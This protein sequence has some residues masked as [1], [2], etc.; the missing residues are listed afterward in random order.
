VQLGGQMKSGQTLCGR[1]LQWF[2]VLRNAER[3]ESVFAGLRD[4]GNFPRFGTPALQR[5]FSYVCTAVGA[6][7][8]RNQANDFYATVRAIESACDGQGPAGLR[9]PNKTPFW[10]A[11]RNEKRRTLKALW[12]RT[13]PIVIAD[14][15]YP[16]LYRDALNV[17]QVLVRQVAVDKLQW[18]AT[19]ADDAETNVNHVWTGPFDSFAFFENYND[20]RDTL[21]EV[22]KVLRRYGY[23]DSTILTGSGGTLVASLLFFGWSSASARAFKCLR[24]VRTDAVRFETGQTEFLRTAWLL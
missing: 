8:G 3:A 24:A 10:K 2:H 13:V 19:A 4:M 16:L 15:S 23:S 20:V 21:P 6:G 17:A 18:D 5:T 14:K 9:F 22:T 12:W 7:L 11:I 1:G